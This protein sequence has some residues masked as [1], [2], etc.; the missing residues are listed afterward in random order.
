MYLTPDGLISLEKSIQLKPYKPREPIPRE[1]MTDA[2]ILANVGSTLFVDIECYPNYWLCSFKLHR[3]NKFIVLECGEGRS[4]NPK[5]LSWIMHSYLTVGFNSDDYDLLVLWLAQHHQ[6]TEQIKE[7]SNDIILYGM[8][9][10]DLQK[11]YHYNCFKTNHIDLIEVCPLRGSLKLYGARLHSK[12]LQDLPI[13]DTKY[14][15]E[16]E[17]NIVRDYNFTDL[18]V[19]EQIF[20]FV[21]ERIELRVAMGI[22]YNEDL[23]SKSDAQIA[24]VVLSK[25]VGKL[26]GSRPKRPKILAGTSYSY[27]PP[28]YLVYRLPQLQQALSQIQKAKFI[29]NENG[30]IIS[31]DALKSTVSIG[32]GIYRLGIGG[33]HSSETNVSYVSTDQTKIYDDDMVSYYPR[34]VTNLG[35]CPIAM[36]TAFLT[37]YEKIILRRIEAKKAKR[38]T[39]ANGK[40]IVINGAGG[41]FSDPWSALFSPQLTIQ[42]TVTGQLVLLMLIEVLEQEGIPVI[43]ANTDGIVK[44][45]DSNKEETLKQIISWFEHTTKFETERTE[46][47]SYYARDVNNYFAVKYDNEVKVKGQYSEKGSQSGTQLDNNPVVLICSD[48]IKKLLTVGTPVEQTI[49]ECKDFTRFVTVRQV[50]GG[51]HKDGGYLGKVVRWY[52]AENEFGTINYVLNNNKVAETEGAKPCMDLPLELPADINYQWYENKCREMLEDISYIKKLRQIEFF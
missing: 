21:K 43:S 23:R 22:E 18:D 50:K 4:F 48:A 35:L 49:R 26:N 32:R 15:T 45:C 36:G 52:Y 11:K 37:A 16:E 2:E 5:F 9:K 14:L 30:K 34:I 12:R 27:K 28:A 13:P 6:D 47:K 19:T 44:L 38:T 40:K 41:K 39:E 20:D 25:E 7:A 42:M 31:P 51:A 3:T 17:I 1:V 10:K 46:Y 33:L 24:E 8:R 29:V